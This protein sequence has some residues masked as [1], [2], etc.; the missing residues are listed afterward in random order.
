MPRIALGLP[1]ARAVRGLA[2]QRHVVGMPR[3]NSRYESSFVDEGNVDRADLR[4]RLHMLAVNAA[5][6]GLTFRKDKA[7]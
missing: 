5:C 7:R 2:A 4:Q 3:S 1:P 6:A